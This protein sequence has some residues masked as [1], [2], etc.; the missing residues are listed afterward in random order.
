M[1]LTSDT[2][3]EE[4]SNCCLKSNK[5]LVHFDQSTQKILKIGTLIG[6]FRAKYLTFD[7]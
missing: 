1:T 7:L 4:K 5:N 2:K 3:F 6:P